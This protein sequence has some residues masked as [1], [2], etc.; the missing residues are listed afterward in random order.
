MGRAVRWA[1]L[2]L[3]ALVVG[4]MFGI[5]LGYDPAGLSGPA[6][7]EVQ[8]AAIRAMN[9]RLPVMGAIV[10]LLTIACAM[11]AKRE[12][13]RA[14]PYLIAAG[15][16]IAAGLITRLLNQPINAVVIT[17]DPHNPPAAWT[18]LRDQWWRWHTLRTAAGVLAL[19]V[20]LFAAEDRPRA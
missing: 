4:V 8:Q 6:Y 17:W 7:V 20:L 13:R 2:L 18:M 14:Y 9:V 5:W 11:L 3:A 10:I 12:G 15:L 16:F 19:A 1:T